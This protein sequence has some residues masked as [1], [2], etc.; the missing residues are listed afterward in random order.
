MEENIYIAKTLG[1]PIFYLGS[2]ND[3]RQLVTDIKLFSNKKDAKVWI[4][5]KKKKYSIISSSIRIL[6]KNK[7]LSY[8]LNNNKTLDITLEIPGTIM[9]NFIS[10]NQSFEVSCFNPESG[11][12]SRS[13][14]S[15]KLISKYS[16]IQ[17]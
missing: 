5:Q 12:W 1:E 7:I 16:L 4:T 15:E 8:V 10:Q 9:N 3:K 17:K 11:F 13:K 14:V 2:S 6:K